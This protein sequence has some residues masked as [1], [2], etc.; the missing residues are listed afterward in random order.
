[1]ARRSFPFR[2]I[3]FCSRFFTTFFVL[4]S[5]ICGMVL[6]IPTS[7][8][9]GH[10]AEISYLLQVACLAGVAYVAISLRKFIAIEDRVRTLPKSLA[11]DESIFEIFRQYAE[12]LRRVTQIP[13]PVFRSAALQQL[14]SIGQ[15]LQDLGNGTLIFENT[16]SWRIVYEQILR[17]KVVYSY[18]SVAWVRNANYWQDEPGQKSLRLNWDLNSNQQISIER[19]FVV[20]DSIWPDPSLESTEKFQQLLIDHYRNGIKLLL[21]RES[22]LANEQDLIADFGIYGSHAIGCQIMD[23]KQRSI[24]FI[25]Q[26]DFNAVLKAE[27]VWERL[28]V[29]AKPIAEILELPP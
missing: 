20:N 15:S 26:F 12:A 11:C 2:P 25:V 3:A 5:L 9:G 24:R 10:D 18:K 27:R 23:E 4:A 1:M 8:T 17:S 6:A 7:L 13:D 21:I 16:E 22:D 28:L 14:D 19:I 29:Y